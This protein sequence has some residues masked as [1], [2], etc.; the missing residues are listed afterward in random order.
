[1][2]LVEKEWI[3]TLAT[4]E[5]SDIVYVDFVETARQLVQELQEE[6]GSY[7]RYDCCLCFSPGC[8]HGFTCRVVS[9]SLLSLTCECP[10]T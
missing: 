1:M 3:V 7:A 8:C 6:V 10:M 2:G 5:I 4:V 9:S